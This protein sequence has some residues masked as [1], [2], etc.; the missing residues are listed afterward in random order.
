VSLE[1]TRDVRAEASPVRCPF[2]HDGVD[3]EQ[4][5]WRACEK[6]LARHHGAC[7]DEAGRC[8]ACGSSAALAR[9]TSPG[10]ATPEPPRVPRAVALELADYASRVK[11]AAEQAGIQQTWERKQLPLTIPRARRSRSSRRAPV[12][13]CGRESSPTRGDASRSRSR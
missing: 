11:A 13:C 9:V 2:C 1:T 5:A 3:V 12:S 8:S 10:V 6:C 7:W 4:D